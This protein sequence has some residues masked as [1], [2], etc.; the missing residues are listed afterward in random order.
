MLSVVIPCHD[1][2]EV[3]PWI[4]QSLRK[5]DVPGLEIICV[6]DASTR[7]LSPIAQR[8]AVRLV[9]LDG[10]PGRRAL[11]RNRGHQQSRNPLT[12]YLDGDVIP[13]PHLPR[14]AIELHEANSGVAIKY[15][16]YGIP[17]KLSADG[18]SEIAALVLDGK[19]NRLGKLLT[20]PVAIDTRPLPRRLRGRRTKIW[21]LCASHCLSVERKS[22][23]RAGGWDLSFSGWGEEDIEL[24]YRLHQC[25]IEFVYPHRRVAAAY[26]VDHPIDWQKNLASLRRNLR[27]FRK[28]FPR[29]WR[30]RLPLL[31]AYL[32]ENRVPE[33][34]AI[35]EDDED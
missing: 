7:P 28:K 14:A 25:G 22:V 4:L 24:A 31:R 34:P 1:N 19:R 2:H 5:S 11:A 16:V 35:L 33:D 18:L 30:A 20:K 23:E 3:L 27:Y 26:H 10:T 8:F 9:R 21:Q 32:R 13:D 6:D 12:L 15:P 17:Q 29:A